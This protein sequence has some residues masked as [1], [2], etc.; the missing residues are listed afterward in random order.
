[1]FRRF[2]GLQSWLNATFI[3]PRGYTVHAD[4]RLERGM[5]VGLPSADVNAAAFNDLFGAGCTKDGRTF[6]VPSAAGG[7]VPSTAGSK[8]DVPSVQ[9]EGVRE[10][11]SEAESF[12]GMR[13]SFHHQ[14]DNLVAYAEFVWNRAGIKLSLTYVWICLGMALLDVI[15]GLITLSQGDMTPGRATVIGLTLLMIV[16]FMFAPR[17]L[18]AVR[19]HFS[20]ARRAPMLAKLS[21]FVQFA[22]RST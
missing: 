8:D 14:G 5:P 17:L 15:A 20:E 11:V 10:G 9:P 3:G 1:M 22:G 18:N 7:S 21:A 2:F 6:F 12:G 16:L 19:E 4:G 13:G